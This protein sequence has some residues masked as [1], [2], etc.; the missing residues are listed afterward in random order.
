MHIST[1]RFFRGPFFE[2][3]NNYIDFI[4]IQLICDNGKLGARLK[5]I[6]P[7]FLVGPPLIEY[8]PVGKCFMCEAGKMG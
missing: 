3:Q 1:I 7:Y 4:N 6:T 2:Q 5:L 8:I